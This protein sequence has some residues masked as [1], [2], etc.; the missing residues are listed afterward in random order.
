MRSAVI[1][2][3][4]LLLFS[5]SSIAQENWGQFRGPNADNLPTVR[6][7]PAKW[8][9]DTNVKWRYDL[10]GSGWSSPVIWGD[11]VLVATAVSDDP[12][13][14]Q[15]AYLKARANSRDRNSRDK[16]QEPVISY[17]LHCLSLT[18]GQVL[19]KS[20]AHKGKPYLP[21]RMENTHAN[22]TPVT[23]G[24][25]I[26]AYF[27]MI[28]LYCYD[29][30]GELLWEKDMGKFPT[31]STWGAGTSPLLWND[32]L[33]MQIDTKEKSFLAALDAATGDERWRIDRDEG[34]NYSTPVIWNNTERTELVTGGKTVRSYDPKSGKV[35]WELNVG[36]G[37]NIISSVSDSELIYVGNEARRDGGGTLFAVKAGAS[38][39][40]TPK[41][42]NATS[43]GVVWSVPEAGISMASPLLFEGSLY[44]IHR[45]GGF[46]YCYN[47]ATGEPYYQKKRIS[48]ARS[49]WATPWAYDGKLFYLDD[50]GTTFVMQP[51]GELKVLYENTI[52]D[53][54]W[55]SPAFAENAIILRGVKS[56]YCIGNR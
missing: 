10:P 32:V 50:A 17:E 24:N 44:L 25:R 38:G 1:I 23:D 5:G 39:D 27:G 49:F 40:I 30:D 19:W 41:E 48:G 31:E 14:E 21:S 12:S 46:A 16:K 28:G 56:M 4:I 42:G 2:A 13:M 47:A 45:N 34:T 37:R 18:T 33:Y 15:R 8:D 55:A 51:G 52:D 3:G 11:K 26:Y 54:F 22:E 29:F 36:G 7:L 6:N 9:A 43:N 20:V 35:L 53:K